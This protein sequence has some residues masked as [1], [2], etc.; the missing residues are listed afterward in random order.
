MNVILFGP[1]GIGKSTIIG[2]LKTLGE[3]AVDLEDVDSRLRYQLPNS[4]DGVFFGAA[5][6]DPKRKYRNAIKV[7]IYAPQ[8]VYA[9]RRL[10]RDSRHPEKA[11]QREHQIEAWMDDFIWTDVICTGPNTPLKSPRDVAL[12]LIRLMEKVSSKKVGE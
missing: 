3:R 12:Y 6:L 4:S 5:D 7:L 2:H 11:S 1:P 8:E 10:E 9:A